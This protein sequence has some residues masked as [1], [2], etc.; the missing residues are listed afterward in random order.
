MA[1]P[2]PVNVR[3]AGMSDE[4]Y[5]ADVATSL[6]YPQDVEYNPDDEELDAPAYDSACPACGA[7]GPC[8]YDVS[9]LPLIHAD[10]DAE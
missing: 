5:W 2:C 8:A 9:G 3:R 10:E 4:D 6:G 7:T 1:E